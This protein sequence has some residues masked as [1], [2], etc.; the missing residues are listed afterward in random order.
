MVKFHSSPQPTNLP[1]CRGQRIWRLG[2]D[3][4]RNQTCEDLTKSVQGLRI[5]GSRKWPSSIY[6]A[7]RTYNSAVD[8][9]L[10]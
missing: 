5:P 6:L 1:L 4:G 10:L 2:S 3:D 8:N 7:D 9:V